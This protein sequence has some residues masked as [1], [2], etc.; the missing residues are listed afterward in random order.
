MTISV[1][2][3]SIVEFMEAQSDF[4]TSYLN[5]ESG[6]LYT[7]SDEDFEHAEENEDW[8]DLAEW[9]TEN[10]EIAKEILETDMY[11]PLPDLYA[12]DEYAIMERF[13]RTVKDEATRED[14]V[15]GMQGQ[16][17]FRRFKETVYANH[18]EKKWFLFRDDAIREIARDWCQENDVM[19]SD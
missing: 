14:L 19:F 17:A 4:T 8:E 11:I 12:M 1:K 13:V 16:G 3:E 5:R 6:L 18:L 2:L 15:A 10:I 9:E 7:I